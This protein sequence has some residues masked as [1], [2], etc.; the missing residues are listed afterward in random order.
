MEANLFTF[1]CS[2]SHFVWPTWVS[3]LSPYFDHIHNYAR[4][5]AGNSY[6]F[7][8]FSTAIADNKIKKGDTVIVQWSSLLREDRIMQNEHKYSLGG[9]L[10]SNPFYKNENFLKYFNVLQKGL[11]LVGYIISVEAVCRQNSINLKMFHMFEP[12]I[13]PNAGEPIRVDVNLIDYG[14][15]QL[16]KY[17]ITEKIKDLSSTS[18]F[19]PESL[20]MLN[21]LEFKDIGYFIP[22]GSNECIEDHHPLPSVHLDYCIKYIHPWLS[23]LT[24]TK[25]VDNI[26]QLYTNI[27]KW[28]EYVKD[29]QKVDSLPGHR[30]MKG[31]AKE[32]KLP[33]PSDLYN[34]KYG[35]YAE[36]HLDIPYK[37]TKYI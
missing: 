12:W 17:Q 15:K 18:T 27:Q 3:C 10:Y 28:T 11:E 31:I 29:K 30:P 26:N 2:Y 6:I 32:W 16:Q 22:F 21:N 37:F 9:Y 1:G 34:T 13:G 20:E 35:E 25:K 36:T 19:F 4:S 5:G 33:L 7:A 23:S 24:S 8:N 14:N